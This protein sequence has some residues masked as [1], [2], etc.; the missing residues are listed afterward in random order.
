MISFKNSKPRFHQ[1][2]GL[3]LVSFVFCYFMVYIYIYLMGS[4]LCCRP[5]WA[6]EFSLKSFDFLCVYVFSLRSATIRCVDCKGAT[7]SFFRSLCDLKPAIGWG[8]YCIF[9]PWCGC[10]KGHHYRRFGTGFGS[11]Y[12]YSEDP[13]V[14]FWHPWEHFGDLGLPRRLQR[15]PPQEAP[16]ET[17]WSQGM[18]L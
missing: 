10:L 14:S 12:L 5:L 2:K 3:V 1:I 16:K 17:L 6:G 7:I 11:Q 18:F 13:G 8:N 15:R 9:L 4:A